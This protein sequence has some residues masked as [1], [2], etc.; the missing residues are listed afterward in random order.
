VVEEDFEIEQLQQA[1]GCRHFVAKHGADIVRLWVSSINY[2]DDVP[3][4]EEECSPVWE[5]PIGAFGTRSDFIGES[6]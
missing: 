3:F 4:S 2:T 6:S 1:D 5:T